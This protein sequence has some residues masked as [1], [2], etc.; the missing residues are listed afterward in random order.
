ME[1]APVARGCRCAVVEVRLVSCAGGESRARGNV[2][3]FI[4]V[5]LGRAVGER[6]K[7]KSREAWSERQVYPT[8]RIIN[9]QPR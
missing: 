7:E 8:S 9:L 5:N 1:V 2:F 3:G 4:N 6:K